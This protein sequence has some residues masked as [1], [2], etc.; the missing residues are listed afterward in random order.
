MRYVTIGFWENSDGLFEP[1]T[2]QTEEGN[3]DSVTKVVMEMYPA[4]AVH[5][6]NTQKRW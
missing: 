6:N 4:V 5:I 1:F 3:R 2:V